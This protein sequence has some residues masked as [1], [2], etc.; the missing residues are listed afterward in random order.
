LKNVS[1]KN[2]KRQNDKQDRLLVEAILTLILILVMLLHI[3]VE[4]YGHHLTAM[5]IAIRVL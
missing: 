5:R 1:D 2:K 4:A 3:M